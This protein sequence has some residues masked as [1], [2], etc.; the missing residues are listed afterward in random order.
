MTLIW[1]ILHLRIING[2]IKFFFLINVPFIDISSST[3]VGTGRMKL[4]KLPNLFN[5]MITLIQQ[6]DFKQID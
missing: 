6:S 4:M 3:G 1:D 5:K 2:E